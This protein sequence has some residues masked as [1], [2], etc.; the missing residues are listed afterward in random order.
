MG[1]LQNNV[2]EYIMENYDV[3]EDDMNEN[4]RKHRLEK[5]QLVNEEVNNAIKDNIT[6]NKKN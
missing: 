2:I 3:I 5:K 6:L 4:T 1:I